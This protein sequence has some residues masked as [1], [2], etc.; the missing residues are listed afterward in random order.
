MGKCKV[1]CTSLSDSTGFFKRN[2]DAIGFS[3]VGALAKDRHLPL[4]VALA[5]LDFNPTASDL[6]LDQRSEATGCRAG[7]EATQLF[8]RRRAAPEGVK[9]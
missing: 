7:S 6:S 1:V 9:Q 5:Q 2:N 3:Q 8:D 4:Q